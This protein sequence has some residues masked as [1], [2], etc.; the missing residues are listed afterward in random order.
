MN[1][2]SEITS[3]PPLSDSQRAALISLLADEDPAVYQ[4]IWSK[5][6]SYGP[7]VVTWLQPYLLD[8]DP[9][10]RR[11]SQAI[12]DHFGRQSADTDFLGFCLRQGEEFDLESGVW[13]LVKTEFP[14]FNEQAYRALLDGYANELK[15]RVSL[16]GGAETIV[17]HIN[18]FLFSELGFRGNEED[19]YDPDNSYLNRVLDNRLGNPISLSLVYIWIARR[20]HLPVAGIGLPGHFICRFQTSKEELYIDAFNSGKLLT[21]VDCVKYLL[22]TSH[23]LEEGHLAPISA[24]RVLL[25]ICANLHQIYTALEQAEHVSRFQRY[26]VA[27]AK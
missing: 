5:L 12:V 24:R 18:E 26:L 21:K 20:M 16:D 27:L 2:T 19:Y 14:N 7:D 4:T 17:A 25:R 8:S 15:R 9:L 13:K 1:L 22:Q 23:T 11:R 10:L 6:L 3:A